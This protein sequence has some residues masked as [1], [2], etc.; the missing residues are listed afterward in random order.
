[1][2]SWIQDWKS[3]QGMELMGMIDSSCFISNPEFM[4]TPNSDKSLDTITESDTLEEEEEEDE[5]LE[6]NGG[7]H[8]DDE[9]EVVDSEFKLIKPNSFTKEKNPRLFIMESNDNIVAMQSLIRS[10]DTPRDAFVFHADRL[11]RLAIEASL[12]HLPHVEKTVTTPTGSLY[13]GVEFIKSN[14]GVSIVPSGDAME[15]D[16]REC[17]LSIRIG[18]ILITRNPESG[19]ARVVYSRFPPDIH[20]RKV[21]K[22]IIE[23]LFPL[24]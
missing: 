22:F 3:G 14:C 21:R 24:V 7:S 23:L 1:M 10:A 20:R 16:L 6:V 13:Q 8:T 11:I 18:K 15:R 5:E 2:W 9:T 19:R 12:N 17:C 4:L